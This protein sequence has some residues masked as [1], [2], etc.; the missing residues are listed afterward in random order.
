[1]D[2]AALRRVTRAYGD[3]FK[4]FENLFINNPI[5]KVEDLVKFF[6][7][8]KNMRKKID[9]E[10]GKSYFVILRDANIFTKMFLEVLHIRL[11]HPI[12]NFMIELIGELG[13]YILRNKSEKEDAL[14]IACSYGMIEIV[15]F[16]LS[17]PEFIPPLEDAFL[18]ACKS[19]SIEL[20]NLLMTRYSYFPSS[21]VSFNIAI[22]YACG[23]LNT[24]LFKFLL[25]V[26]GRG[27]FTL[28]SSV[29]SAAIYVNRFYVALKG[30]S[31]PEMFYL[32]LDYGAIPDN[33]TFIDACGADNMELVHLLLNKYPID[34]AADDNMAFR[35]ACEHEATE[36]VRFLL[37]VRGV[38]PTARNNEGFRVAC[39]T[40]N[41]DLVRILLFDRRIDPT[42]E[43]N[44][45]LH[46]A[47]HYGRTNLVRMLLDDYRL[48]RIDISEALRIAT[49]NG[50]VAIIRLL[51]A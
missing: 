16:I 8:V 6:K 25:K 33:Q 11:L 19:G 4:Y 22:I 46:Q 32:L 18:Q 50:D 26:K 48:L 41:M 29:L 13:N 5:Y 49:E 9:M 24:E 2:V 3:V 40:G 10:S 34:P 47:C 39:K 12:C 21:S 17:D 43:N 1:M 35:K 45:S 20:V 37:T 15:Q 36:A 14:I 27:Y 31:Q 23:S 28:E 7:G 51:K 38:D 44:E 30:Y 42:A